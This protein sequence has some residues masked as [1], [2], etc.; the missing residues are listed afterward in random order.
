[1]S[2]RWCQWPA[3]WKRPRDCACIGDPPGSRY[4]VITQRRRGSVGIARETPGNQERA[5]RNSAHTSMRISSFA[6]MCRVS[7][8]V[9]SAVAPLRTTWLPTVLPPLRTEAT[10]PGVAISQD[11]QM[12]SPARTS[13]AKT[14][15]PSCRC[16]ETVR[17]QLPEMNRACIVHQVSKCAPAQGPGKSREQERSGGL[18]VPYMF[19]KPAYHHLVLTQSAVL[20]SPISL[21]PKKA[22]S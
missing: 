17:K 8:N 18:V 10:A 3:R 4:V 13:T 9:T 19:A 7:P 1:M 12:S 20:H 16:S 14:V 11:L 6:T 22:E 2:D 21:K 5:Q 15:A